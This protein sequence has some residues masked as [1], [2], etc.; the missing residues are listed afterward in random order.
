MF[1]IPLVYGMFWVLNKIKNANIKLSNFFVP[2]SVSFCWFCC[3]F[4]F[5]VLPL[6]IS[7][8]IN[9]EN[10]DYAYFLKSLITS[11]SFI[12]MLSVTVFAVFWNIL[13]NK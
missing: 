12:V 4:P 6:S 9:N 10:E 8:F 7:I 1:G 5:C 2:S 13:M 3:I 11:I